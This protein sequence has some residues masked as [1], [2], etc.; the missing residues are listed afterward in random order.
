MTTCQQLEAANCDLKFDIANCDVKAR[1]GW[2][3]SGPLSSAP[4]GRYSSAQGNALGQKNRKKKSPEGATQVLVANTRRFQITNCD[5]KRPANM[6]CKTMSEKN[7]TSL[8]VTIPIERVERVILIIRGQK[9]L[10]DADLAALYGVTTTRLNQ[11]V[12]RNMDRFPD[13]FMLR[14]TPDERNSL[15]SQFVMSNGR[16]GRR[17]LPYAFTQEGVAMLSSVLNSPRA[18]AVNIQIMRAFVRLREMLASHADLARKLEKLEK[19]YDGQFHVIFDAI[20]Q[21]VAEPAPRPKPPI[22]FH[23]ES[24]KPRRTAALKTASR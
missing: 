11:A 9:V 19:K 24:R 2:D 12:K 16:G 10:L 1:P 18:I 21:L 4:T 13:D 15:T 22:G 5:F 17:N 20:R 8:T 6:G 7:Q 3:A 23:T 14:L